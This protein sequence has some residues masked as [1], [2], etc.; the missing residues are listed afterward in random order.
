MKIE[1]RIHLVRAFFAVVLGL[2]LWPISGKAQVFEVIH[3][4]VIEGGFEFESL[5]GVTLDDVEDGDERSAHEIAIGY[6]PTDFW[7][8]KFAIEIANPEGEPGEYEA[9]EWENVFLLPFGEGHGAHDSHDHGSHDHGEDRFFALEAVGIFAAL[10]VPNEGGFDSGA[11]E[12]GPIAEA[13]IG[14]VQTIANFFFGIPFES[15]E[16]PGIA[17]A[18]QVKYPVSE[19]FGI[20][21][22]SFGEVENVFE[23]DTEDGYFLGPA[24][25]SEFDLGRDRILE[26]RAAL[27]FGLTNDTPDAILSVNLELKF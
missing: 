2:T 27:L 5:N 16:D 21:F 23:T 3:P 8:T 13:T 17:Y 22:E 10:E 15:E 19:Q 11:I 14:P 4:D 24:V 18:V 6:A 12:V 20:G 7:K 26:P 9:F 25:F 1:K